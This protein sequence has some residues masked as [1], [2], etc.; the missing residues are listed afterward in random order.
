LYNRTAGNY[1]DKGIYESNLTGAVNTSCFLDWNSYNNSNTKINLSYELNE[2]GTKIYCNETPPC[3]FNAD[4]DNSSFH[5]YLES[6]NTS[7]SPIVYNVSLECNAPAPPSFVYVDLQNVS[8]STYDTTPTIY[9]NYTG[10]N[11]SQCTLYNGSTSY[12]SDTFANDSLQSITFSS[13]LSR[14]TNY[15]DVKVLCN[16]GSTTNVSSSIWVYVL[17]YEVPVVS[18]INSSFIF[19]VTPTITLADVKNMTYV[20]VPYDDSTGVF[21]THLFGY[22]LAVASIIGFVG[23]LVSLKRGVSE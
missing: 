23:V 8:F 7:F 1:I 18:M 9:F 3:Y 12:G 21:N 19:S 11:N 2:S 5:F 22:F 13:A 14:N 17:D 16:D 20:Y 10:L 4:A 6:S 15:T